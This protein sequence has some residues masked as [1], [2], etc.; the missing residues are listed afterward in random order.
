MLTY[1]RGVEAKLASLFRELERSAR[2][3]LSEE[4]FASSRQRAKLSEEGFASSRQRHERSVA[5]RY[6]GQSFELE[7]NAASGDLAANFHRAH[8]IRY[9]YS[10]K[11]NAIEI[12]SVRLRSSGLV[13][14]RREK[15]RKAVSRPAKAA[16]STYAYFEGK[17]SRVQ[18]YER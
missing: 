10:Q 11:E 16:S 7:I 2:A 18:V 9:G 12:V 6:Q 4:G 13:E 17:R 14:Q 5:M 15:T 3:K 1:Q 8:E